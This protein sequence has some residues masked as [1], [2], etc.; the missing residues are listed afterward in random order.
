MNSAILR[1]VTSRMQGKSKKCQSAHSLQWSFCLSLR[2]H[3][4]AKR[5]PPANEW[6]FGNQNQRCRHSAADRC[7]RQLWRIGKLL[8]PLHVRH[9]EAQAGDPA[10]GESC[11]GGRHEGMIHSR[12][13]AVRHY[14]ASPCARRVL[15]QA[16]NANGFAYCDADRFD[17]RMRH[18]RNQAKLG[19][20]R[21]CYT[22]EEWD[23]SNSSKR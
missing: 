18:E 13:G 23:K 6:T 1:W 12:A 19:W 11:G 5:F 16:R 14:V 8:A 10:Q 21:C 2:C 7:L 15:Q 22:T 4:A 20:I 9:V 17:N 3:P